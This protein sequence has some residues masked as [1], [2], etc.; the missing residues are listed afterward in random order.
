MGMVVMSASAVGPSS[1]H[2][3]RR[4]GVDPGALLMSYYEWDYKIAYTPQTYFKHINKLRMWRIRN[5][6]QMDE[7]CWFGEPWNKRVDS[8]RRNFQFAHIAQ[9]YGLNVLPNFNTLWD[10]DV[11]RHC[12]PSRVPS[13]C[14]DGAHNEH[15]ALYREDQMMLDFL[16]REFDT[17]SAILITGKRIVG[18]L[19]WATAVM[20][21]Y[22]G[23]I[24]YCPSEAS[25]L[26]AGSRASRRYVLVQNVGNET[27]TST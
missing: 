4:N 23:K 1:M 25:F 15:E 17:R 2:R 16:C 7:S 12:L 21:A 3:A 20:D 27:L 9:H 22:G 5:V 18:S 11:C 13:V 6:I 24:Y 19:K 26:C 8:M 10:E 14:I